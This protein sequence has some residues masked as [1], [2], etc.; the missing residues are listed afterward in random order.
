MDILS[1]GSGAFTEWSET[2]VRQL[3]DTVK[4]LSADRIRVCL[5]GGIEIEQTLGEGELQ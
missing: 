3:V 4:V 5:R 1:T 2:L